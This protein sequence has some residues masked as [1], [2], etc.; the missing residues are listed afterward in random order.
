MDYLKRVVDDMDRDSGVKIG[1]I[2]CPGLPEKLADR[3]QQNLTSHLNG[4][5][6]NAEEITIDV[7]TD[8][9][10]GAAENAQKLIDETKEMKDDKCWDFALC[11]TN[12]PVFDGKELVL[13]DADYRNGVGQISIPAFGAFPFQFRVRKIV[14]QIMRELY[15]HRLQNTQSKG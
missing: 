8:S 15:E 10:V 1:L 3:L 7:Y 11:L 13:A 2:P 4:I 5:M 9:L 6:R 12:W 14:L